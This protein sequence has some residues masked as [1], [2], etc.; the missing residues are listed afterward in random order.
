[1]KGSVFRGFG[2]VFQGANLV[3]KPG[4]RR[5]V[6]IPLFVNFLIFFGGF[7]FAFSF[8]SDWIDGLMASWPSYLS[9]L[10]WIMWP[11]FA[12]LLLL[13]SAYTFSI[14]ANIIASPFNGLLAEKVEIH[15]RGKEVLQDG[16]WKEM[17]RTI[18][19]T[20]MR[21]LHKLK[22][23]IPRAIPLL[24]LSFIPGVNIVAFLFA[25]WM[26]AI[27]YVDLP[28]DNHK[29]LFPDMIKTLKQHRLTCIGFGLFVVGLAMIPV[30]NWFIMPVAVAGA[31][32][33][34]VKEISPEPTI[35][36]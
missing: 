29:I 15:L 6:Y 36:S 17:M 16:G 5:F 8:F 11:V 33:F 10:E 20:L 31:T 23:Y 35:V 13:V 32:A 28:M 1:M 12:L 34:W 9:F 18:P 25:G 22:Y 21:E 3:R 19:A 7:H 27:Q 14:V 24:I 2:Y 4:L 26:M 30:V